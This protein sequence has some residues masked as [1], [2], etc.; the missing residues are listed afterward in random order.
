[1]AGLLW[2]LL[3]LE[4]PGERTPGRLAM[5]AGTVLAFIT[6]AIPLQLEKQ[7]ITIGFALLA[8]ALAWLWRRIPHN[9][10]V[11]W[12]GGLLLTVFVRLVL[13]PEVFSYHPRAAMAILNWYLYTYVVSATAFFVT[14]WLLRNN[15]RVIPGF[16]R[17]PNWQRSVA[18]SCCL[19]SLTLKLPTTI[20]RG[21]N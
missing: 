16:R 14:A 17:S 8:A 18:P 6:V 19:C 10:L 12:T 11:Y 21:P 20:R 2:K 5:V 3:Q 9:G 1:M 13:N 4:S 7:W 15:G